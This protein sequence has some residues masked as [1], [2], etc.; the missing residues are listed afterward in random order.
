[1]LDSLTLLNLFVFKVGGLMSKDDVVDNVWCLSVSEIDM[2]K[3]KGNILFGHE[4][5]T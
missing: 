4:S 3:A 1:M 2:N 5:F